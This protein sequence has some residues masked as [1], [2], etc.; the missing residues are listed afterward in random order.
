MY[1]TIRLENIY[2]IF[3]DVKNEDALMARTV[4]GISGMLLYVRTGE[5]LVPDDTYRMN[6]NRISMKIWI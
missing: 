5:P 6:D 2:Q 1:A 3:T 4:H